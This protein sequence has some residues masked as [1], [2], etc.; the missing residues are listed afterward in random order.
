MGR[1][2]ARGVQVWEVH[3][4]AEMRKVIGCGVLIVLVLLLACPV[5][6]EA[7]GPRVFIGGHIWLGP[8]YWGPGPWWGPPYYYYPAP[9][10][11]VQEPPVYEQPAPPPQA[12]AYWYYCPNPQGYYPYIRQCPNGWM[13]VVPPT[14]PP[15]R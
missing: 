7:R 10:V 15:T 1:A 2:P 5:P 13:Q 12:P 8:G 11:I 3:G 9:P 4:G 6:S 14:T